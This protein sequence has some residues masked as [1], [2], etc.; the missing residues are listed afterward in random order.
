MFGGVDEGGVVFGVGVVEFEVAAG[1]TDGYG[2]G[3]V[4]GDDG[5]WGGGGGFC[6]DGFELRGFA[7]EDGGD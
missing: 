3:G 5:E 7:E 4:A 2:C 1:F 6:H